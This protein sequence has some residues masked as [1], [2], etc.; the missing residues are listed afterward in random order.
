MRTRRLDANGDWTFGRGRLSYATKSEAVRQ[1]VAT[2]LKSFKNDWFL[3][4]DHGI[5][6]L[7]RMSRRGNRLKLESDIRACILSTDGVSTLDSFV[8]SFNS[9]L[10]KLSVTASYTDIYGESN[11]VSV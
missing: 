5:A 8:S 6:W 4:L 10:R 2:R 9:K 3:N 7:D 1:K 11:E